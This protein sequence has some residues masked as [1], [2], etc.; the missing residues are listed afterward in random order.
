MR[1][2]VTFEAFAIQIRRKS[3][4]EAESYQYWASPLQ[5]SSV[6][7]IAGLICIIMTRPFLVLSF[8]CYAPSSAEDETQT[9]DIF[10]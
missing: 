1:T 4:G 8:T 7:L 2:R 6:P 10:L 5:L 3:D 9:V